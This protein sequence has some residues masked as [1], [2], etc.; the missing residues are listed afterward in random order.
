MAQKSERFMG[1]LL[2]L[3]LFNQLL[4]ISLICPRAARDLMIAGI[5][6]CMRRIWHF[7]LMHGNRLT[8]TMTPQCT[9]GHNESG[10]NGFTW[11]WLIGTSRSGPVENE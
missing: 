4:S 5:Y 9:P 11:H 8:S 2:T 3:H 6:C 10:G 7:L 1:Q